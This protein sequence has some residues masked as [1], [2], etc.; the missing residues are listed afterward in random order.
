MKKPEADGMILLK[1]SS[2][3][4][5]YMNS[6]PEIKTSPLKDYRDVAGMVWKL[7]KGVLGMILWT[8][9]K[10]GKLLLS[11]LRKTNLPSSTGSVK[12]EELKHSEE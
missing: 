2:I 12:K 5:L 10:T 1:L 4:P 6:Q 7:G 3:Q 9:V 11:Q 8:T